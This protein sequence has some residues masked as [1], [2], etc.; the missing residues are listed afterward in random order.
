M[1]RPIG[2][3]VAGTRYNL[4]RFDVA[5]QAASVAAA[6]AQTQRPAQSSHLARQLGVSKANDMQRCCAASRRSKSLG[7]AD[8]TFAQIL[9]EMEGA[10]F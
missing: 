6:A 10:G 5:F 4:A 8:P 7:P 1:M 9:R 2:A 3:Q